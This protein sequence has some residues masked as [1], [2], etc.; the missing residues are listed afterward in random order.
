MVSELIK[1]LDLPRGYILH[2]GH[3][4]YCLNKHPVGVLASIDGSGAIAVGN[5]YDEGMFTLD[6]AQTDYDTSLTC[7]ICD[8]QGV[9]L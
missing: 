1:A 9:T 4:V 3:E 7:K 6:P 5:A 2:D 8:L